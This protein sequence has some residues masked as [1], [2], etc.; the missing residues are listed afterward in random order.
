MKN[1]LL[2]AVFSFSFALS[3]GQTEVEKV[4]STIT[5]DEIKGH[6]YF[7]ADDLLEGRD[8]GT[9][10]NDIAALYL[11]NALRGYGVDPNPGN[12]TYYQEV[13]L[14]KTKLPQISFSI[15]NKTQDKIAIISMAEL[16][17]N[18]ELVYLNYGLE[19]DYSG[20]DVNGKLVLLKGSTSEDSDPISAWKMIDEKK[21]L[22]REAGALGIIE[23]VKAVDTI[24]ERI[25]MAF[26]TERLELI[27]GAEGNKSDP[28]PYLWIQENQVEQENLFNS[29]G[30]VNAELK[31]GKAKIDTIKSKNVIGI[32]EGGDPELKNEYIIYSAHYDHV[33]IG[34]ADAKGD[35]IYNGARDNAVG[36]ATVLSMAENFSRYPAK[37]SAIFL[38]FTGEEGGLMGSRFYVE[39]PV[40]PLEQ[41]VYVF[42]SDNAGYNDTTVATIFGLERTTAAPHIKKA[43]KAFGITAIDDP[44]PDQNLFDRSDNVVFAEKGIPAPTFSLGFRSFDGDVEKYYHQPGDE[45]DTLDYDYL[46]KFFQTYVLAG[47]LIAN[48]PETPFWTAGDKYE[49]AG[50]DLYSK[51]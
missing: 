5:E 11:A 29:P 7:L 18:T 2:L 4:T 46:L 47:R 17:Y 13:L 30:T 36:T 3:S 14:K 48:D 21:E 23:I 20:K 37:R 12:E 50:K 6:I 26:N 42:N 43:A 38:F 40:I 35:S 19:E 44:A 1:I 8:T 34:T 39:N 25:E 33:G 9:P 22:A 45:A 16:D 28:F 10:G 15:D 27:E 32:I 51:Q 41:V 49:T 24:W 31:I